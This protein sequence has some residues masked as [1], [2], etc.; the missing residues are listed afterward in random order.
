MGRTMVTAG[1][2]AR[3]GIFICFEG[4]E[5]SGKSTQAALLAQWLAERGVPHRLVREPG[6]TAV[7][8]E[9]R[10]LMLEGEDLPARAELLLALAARA[11]HVDEVLAPALAAGEVVVADRY[12]LSTLAYQ[13]YGRGLPLEE[14]RRANEFAT[15][16]LKPDITL[17]LDVPL[18]VGESRRRQAGREVDRIERAGEAFHRR[19]AEAYALLAETEPGVERVSATAGPAEVHAEI[20]RRLRSRFPETFSLDAG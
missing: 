3:R 17:L 7:G 15:G 4:I 18:A 19:V 2:A 9:I 1:R 5:G 16:G 6:G 12:E 20:L 11:V 14:V 8:E 13:G 10:R